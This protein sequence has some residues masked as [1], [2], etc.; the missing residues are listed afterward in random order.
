MAT[1]PL[2]TFRTEAYELTTSDTILY[3]TPS[4]ITT[5]VLG[6]L[7]ANI[8]STDVPVRVTLVKNSTD[9]VI[10]KDFEVPVNDTAEVTSGKL[11]V[12]EGCSLKAYAGSDNSI[13][14]V[15]SILETTNE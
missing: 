2:N 1:N 5:I 6:A 3:T 14:L 11:V 9:F 7:A 13:N 4:G 8:G 10:L 15:L 12:E